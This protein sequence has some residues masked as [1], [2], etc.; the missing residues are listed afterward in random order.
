MIGMERAPLE[1]MLRCI[2]W[3][4]VPYCSW[5]HVK[6]LLGFFGKAEEHMCRGPRDVWPDLRN[7]MLKR[8]Q[9]DW[10][11]LKQKDRKT[12]LQH[13]KPQPKQRFN[14][15]ILNT[16]VWLPNLLSI[17]GRSTELAALAF[18][19]GQVSDRLLSCMFHAWI[20]KVTHLLM[21][22]TSVNHHV[23]VQFTQLHDHTREQAGH[24][25]LWARRIYRGFMLDT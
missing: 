24:P 16:F 25:K 5:T 1:W 11:T 22:L 8:K 7:S 2:C 3:D 4:V 18:L 14:R 19:L 13:G 21:M 15:Y 23:S 12:P 10:T 9:K 20:H 6:W 17:L